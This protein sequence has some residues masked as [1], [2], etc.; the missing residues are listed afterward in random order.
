MDKILSVNAKPPPRLP[1][2]NFSPSFSLEFTLAAVAPDEETD[3]IELLW[4]VVIVAVDIWDV[5]C[6][7]RGILSVDFKGVEGIF[8]ETA[9]VTMG[10][11]VVTVPFFETEETSCWRFCCGF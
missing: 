10:F 9:G 7:I 11:R 3:V 5:F 1:I 4:A 2:S 8:V 6:E